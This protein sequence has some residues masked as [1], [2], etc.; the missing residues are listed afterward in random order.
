MSHCPHILQLQ[1]LAD[2]QCDAA[3]A[4]ALAEHLA[5]C[6]ACADK[7]R[8]LRLACL[9]LHVLTEAPPADLEA[10]LHDAVRAVQPLAPLTCKQALEWVSLRLDG[11]LAHEQAQRLEAHLSA[12]GPCHRAAAEMT[13]TTDLLRATEPEAAPVGLLARVQA[14]AELAAPARPAPAPR[15]VLRRW[16]MGLAGVAAAAAVFLAVLLNSLT[17]VTQAPIPVVATAPATPQAVATL[18][19]TPVAA[20]QL[21]PAATPESSRGLIPGHSTGRSARVTEARVA[22]VTPSPSPAPRAVAPATPRKVPTPR[23]PSAPAG[24]SVVALG[25]RGPAALDLAPPALPEVHAEH[26]TLEMVASAHSV[27]TLPAVPHTAPTS[28]V[29][30]AADVPKPTPTAAD[31]RPAPAPAPVRSRSN[32]VSRP[33]SAEREI[34]RSSD[35]STRLADARMDLARDARDVNRFRSPGIAITH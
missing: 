11:E 17:P 3:E 18:P 10:R 25:S 20:P 21:G 14:A 24:L 22:T 7:L 5:A 32:W 12:C 9:P 13:L 26:P 29:R 30:V 34:Y 33:V 23:A 15:S 16:G 35:T 4:R 8:E 1:A 31:D 6:P 2:G 19:S 28:P 27:T